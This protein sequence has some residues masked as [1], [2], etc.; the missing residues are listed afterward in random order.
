MDN[1]DPAILN[2][3]SI[4]F[5]ESV[6]NLGVMIDQSLTG[7]LWVK[8]VCWK[9]F[10]PINRFYRCGGNYQSVSVRRTL[11]NALIL[12]IIDYGMIPNTALTALNKR[13]LQRVQ[14]SCIRFVH[15]MGR[16]EALSTVYIDANCLR[17]PNRQSWL[18]LMF[19]YK[20]VVKDAGPDYIKQS[21][22]RE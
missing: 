9:A 18:V 20:A 10:A 11:V 15:G 21:N 22:S 4:P 7:E 13:K 5:V 8:Q 12:P 3:V 1:I 2:G 14:N 16:S 6:K 17:I 19:F